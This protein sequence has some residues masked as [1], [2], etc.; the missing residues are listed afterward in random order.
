ME[1]NIILSSGTPDD[2]SFL[3]AMLF[4]AAYWRTDQERPSLE[5][6]LARD[7]LVYLLEDWRR[8][9]DTAVIAVSEDDQQ[10]GAAWY[11]F[12]WPDKHSYGYISP[13]IP[14][15]AIAVRAEFRGMGIGRQLLDSLLEAAASQ[16]IKKIS[17]S[18]EVENPA[19]NLYRQYG[20]QP[21]KRNK[22]D[23][24]MAAK[25]SDSK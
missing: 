15:L 16:G 20:F 5:K 23:W 19:L 11:R 17:L 2:L 21:V 25:T 24:V 14:E 9:G 12:W 22:G 10:I 6:G 4:E 18:V 13:E 7:D 3:K 8:E 1:V